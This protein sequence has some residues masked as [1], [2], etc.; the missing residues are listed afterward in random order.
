LNSDDF[1]GLVVLE[2]GGDNDDDVAVN[3]AAADDTSWD[4]S[5]GRIERKAVDISNDGMGCHIDGGYIID[6]Y[7]F[8]RKYP[9]ESII[10]FPS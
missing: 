5:E 3:D 7:F 1:S 9:N 4:G 6:M 10:I 2:F 8:R